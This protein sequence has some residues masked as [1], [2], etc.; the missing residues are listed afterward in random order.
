[1]ALSL[2][3]LGILIWYHISIRLELKQSQEWLT[4]HIRERKAR[5]K[6]FYEAMGWDLP[7]ERE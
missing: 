7:D 6:A 4:N 2:F 5:D 3:A 1:M